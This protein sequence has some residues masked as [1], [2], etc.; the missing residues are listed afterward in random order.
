MF[1]MHRLVATMTSSPSLTSAYLR[2]TPGDSNVEQLEVL[3]RGLLGAWAGIEPSMGF[4][5]FDFSVGLWNA[6][7]VSSLHEP[8]R[9]TLMTVLS[10]T[11]F[12]VLQSRSQARAKRLL[13]GEADTSP[14]KDNLRQLDYGKHQIMESLN[15]VQSLH[16]AGSARSVRDSYEVLSETSAP[17]LECCRQ[18]LQAVAD[19]IQ[20]TNNRRWLK[21]LSKDQLSESSRLHSTA[22]ERLREER[23]RF[24]PAATNALFGTHEH[25]FNADG[26]FKHSVQT[27][28]Q[29]AG[30]FIGLNF[31]D[32]L[33][34]H[35]AALE[36][37]LEQTV[38]LERG[39]HTY[40]MWFP[41]NLR[42]FGAW[43]FGRSQTPTLR[44]SSA[45]DIPELDKG[46]LQEMQDKLHSPPPHVKKRN[47]FSTLV[48]GFG[49]W[50]SNEEGIFAFRA[51]I[52]TLA[53]AVIAANTTTAGFFQREKGL[54]ALIMAQTGLVSFMADFT[55]GV[56]SRLFGTLL[57]GVVGMLGWY[58]GSGDGP[59]NPYGL[60]AVTAVLAIVLMW[61]RLFAPP[62]FLQAVIMGGATVLLVIG[63]GYIDT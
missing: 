22:L 50:L 49:D 47:K 55:Y 12:A 63:Y 29:L 13:Q 48:L 33:V 19:C 60:A 54:W 51:V 35:A 30:L 17:L 32:R 2:S 5:T 11:D 25:L 59:G 45:N 16:G 44:A 9:R 8:L 52:A 26:R 62:Q 3:R 4:L 24:A 42:K 40:R 36:I 58:I 20:N 34:R 41:T 7:D 23:A 28:P 14:D 46:G 61:L 56:L 39:R 43:A 27:S 38:L 37:L 18:A 10:L 57:G 53:I 31:E 15:M 21:R 1:G 6:Q